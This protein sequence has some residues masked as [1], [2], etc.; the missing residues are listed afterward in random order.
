[1]QFAIVCLVGFVL[2]VATNGAAVRNP[3]ADVSTDVLRPRGQTREEYV[4][5]VVEYWTP[6]RMASAQPMEPIIADSNELRFPLNPHNDD[7]EKILTRSALPVGTRSAA[8]P[9]ACGKAYFV[10]NGQN[11]LCSGSVVT[12]DNHDTV[13]TAGHCVFDTGRQ[14]FASKWAFVPLY[15]LGSRPHGTFVGRKLATKEGWTDDRDFNYDVGIVLMEPNDKGQHIQDAAGGL[16]ITLNAPKAAR[17]NAFGYPVNMNSG[18]TMSTCA[19]TSSAPTFIVGFTGVQLQ[20]GMTGG[21]S[22]GPWIQQYNTNTNY[23]QQFSVVSFGIS[24][25]PG[26]VF[27]PYFTNANIGSLYDLHQDQ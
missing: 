11:Y 13:V 8:L 2:A 1:M 26:N 7:P 24:N 27:G 20:C 3:S 14:V 18:E 12:A 17:T 16:G 22:G 15:S 25:R 6:E 19:A 5:S 21:S 4:R 10:M 23:G 9:S